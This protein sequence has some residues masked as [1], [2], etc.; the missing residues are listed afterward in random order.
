[1]MGEL[2]VPPLLGGL[3]RFS[4]WRRLQNHTRITSFS[5]LSCSAIMVISSEV[6]FW[7]WKGRVV[8]GTALNDR[9]SCH[10]VSTLMGVGGGGG[11]R[12]Q[13]ANRPAPTNVTAHSRERMAVTL[14]PVT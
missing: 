8:C 3:I 13:V 4:F 6:G 2:L 11:N 10:R 12:M 7:F 14:I 5:M 9:H 1:M